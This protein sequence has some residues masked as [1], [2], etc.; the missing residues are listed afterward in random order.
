MPHY[1]RRELM[2]DIEIRRP[3]LQAQIRR[4]F[5]TTLGSGVV[6]LDAIKRMAE[7]IET[8]KH[9]SARHSHLDRSLQPMVR[10]G[11]IGLREEHGAKRASGRCAGRDAAVVDGP[12]CGDITRGAG[13]A[14]RGK[15]AGGRGI[16]VLRE[17]QIVAE[18]P[19]ISRGHAEIRGD[20][21]LNG[22][23]QLI[24][25]RPLEILSETEEWTTRSDELWRNEW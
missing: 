7:G 11:L 14:G 15:S 24:T 19:H 21:A 20:L 22:Q 2:A 16:D 23:I 3:V 8:I 13:R 18:S 1:G 4:V 10:S 17:G 12:A 6:Q 9:Y 25:V 5:R